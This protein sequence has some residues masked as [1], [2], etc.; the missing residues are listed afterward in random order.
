MDENSE[1]QRLP[2][3]NNPPEFVSMEKLAELG[4]LYWKLNPKD[5]ESDEQL[6]KIR[7]SRGYSCMVFAL[8]SYLSLCFFIF[9]LQ[10]ILWVLL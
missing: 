10:F 4:V 6:K 2:H 3:Q 8:Y 7:Q 5:Y 9:F 1:D